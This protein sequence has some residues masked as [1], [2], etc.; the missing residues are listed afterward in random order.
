MTNLVTN[1]IY[2]PTWSNIEYFLIMYEP[3]SHLTAATSGSN[4][5]SVFK[6]DCN[7]VTILWLY[8]HF[9]HKS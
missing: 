5:F 3:I 9:H 7:K 6:K 1:I 4:Y 8:Y 2:I